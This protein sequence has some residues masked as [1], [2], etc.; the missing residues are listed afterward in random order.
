MRRLLRKR[1]R[2][3]TQKP[4]HTRFA[5]GYIAGLV[6]GVVCGAGVW[7]TTQTTLDAVGE[8]NRES[9]VA[10]SIV[11]ET[12][13]VAATLGAVE[14]EPHSI[15]LRSTLGRELAELDE[16]WAILLASDDLP[17][18]V[19]LVLA[20]SSGLGAQMDSFIADASA[21]AADA[22]LG[23]AA[24]GAA[25]GVEAGRLESTAATM[26]GRLES[27]IASFEARG[28]DAIAGMRTT[29]HATFVFIAF[30][31]VVLVG[32]L[33]RP[34]KE[35]LKNESEALRD[36]NRSHKN[37]AQRQEL[38]SHLSDG[39]EAAETEEEAQLVVGRAF[40]RLLPDHPVEMLLAGTDHGTLRQTVTHP[41][42]GGPGCGVEDPWTCPAV[43]RGRTMNYDD[44][45]AINACPHLAKREGGACAATCVPVSFMGQSMGVLHTTR[46]VG[47]EAPRAGN[48]ILGLIASQVSIRLGTL[49]SFAQVEMQASTD[50]LTGL[51]NRRATEDRLR[52]LLNAG[53][54]GALAMADL[55]QFKLLN[56]RYGHDAGDRALRMFAEAVAE[57]L[58]GDDWI[59]RW[60]GEEFLLVMPGLDVHE[61]KEAL[62]RV[63]A[64]LA[65][66]CARAEAPSVTV[67]MGVVDTTAASGADDLV[68]LADDALLV[69]KAQ[70]RDRVITGPVLGPIPDDAD[71]ITS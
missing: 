2:K 16:M 22:S 15:V 8:S 39:L 48:E 46:A 33:L 5:R 63:R 23:T 13:S 71:A 26:T 12:R 45:R 59:G 68:R 34:L 41:Q 60:G 69:A 31:M 57:A 28:D 17:D 3:R 50:A 62:D 40:S 58:R 66:A 42:H 32:V 35:Q 55:D 20:G 61:A 67:S 56:D 21:L 4:L 9:R 10:N 43:R 54:G 18:D 29:S 65:D 53:T 49:R 47:A 44:S 6:A 70:G 14:D 24:L 51:P 52:R 36:A 37:E 7:F 11:A 1:P 38:A 27:I 30:F 19:A 25:D 64:H